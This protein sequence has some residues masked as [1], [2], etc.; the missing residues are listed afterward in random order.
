MP[1]EASG[2]S[3]EPPGSVASVGIKVLEV[4]ADQARPRSRERADA[5]S[6]VASEGGKGDL[7]HRRFLP[8]SGSTS[9]RTTLPGASASTFPPIVTPLPGSATVAP[10]SAQAAC[11]IIEQLPLA[12]GTLDRVRDAVSA[13]ELLA[14]IDRR[15][16]GLSLLLPEVLEHL[17]QAGMRFG[18][19][20]RRL[21]GLIGR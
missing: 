2:G 20:E 19:S 6:R 5:P 14:M 11:E 9:P 12:A 13:P 10:L 3:S 21:P 15:T 1:E 16:T 17:G 4:Q 7:D 8:N 18:I